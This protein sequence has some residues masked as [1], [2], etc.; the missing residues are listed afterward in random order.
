MTSNKI[1]C[2]GG[3]DIDWTGLYSADSFPLEGLPIEFNKTFGGVAHN[4]TQN[5]KSIGYNVEFMSA[6]GNDLIGN[7][8]IQFLKE[9]GLS[10]DYLIK[11]ENHQ[12]ASVIFV[13][14]NN[15][16]VL[17]T[18]PRT[19]I[20]DS[21]TSENLSSKLSS[22]KQFGTWIIDTDLCEEAIQYL[23][24]VKPVDTTLYA[25]IACPSKSN[26]VKSILN[27]L[28]GLFL[29]IEEASYMIGEEIK[30]DE[31]ILKSAKTI[32]EQGAKIVFMTLGER[33]VCVATEEFQKIIPAYKAEIYDTKGAGDA[34]ATGVIAGL[35]DKMSIE[36]S[37]QQGLAAASLAI[38]V[39]GKTYG[40]LSREKIKERR[41]LNG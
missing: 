20:Y 39:K 14:G 3:A 8:F 35:L 25:V 19:E 34:F 28:D 2:I 7:Q 30:T 10:S 37:V 13:I 24:L 41:E 1:L 16:K 32:K 38:E 11:L 26:R 36:G 15:G 18:L 6:I 4:I 17:L 12:T 21:F 31:Q 27:M 22:M 33:G 5:L 9:S 40:M 29:N 23:T